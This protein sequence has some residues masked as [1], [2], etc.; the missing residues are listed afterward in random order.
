MS[1]EARRLS[2]IVLLRENAGERHLRLTL[3]DPEHGL[4][5]CLY[6]PAAKSGAATVTPDLFDTCEATLDTPRTGETSRFVKEYRLVLRRD[7][8]GRDYARLTLACRLASVLAK[9][10]H[11]PES[12]ARLAELADHA[13]ASLA[14]KPRPDAAYFKTLWL[15]ARDEGWAVKEDFLTRLRP[16]ERDLATLL[17]ATPL[18]AIDDASAPKALV[19]GLSQA[20]ER[21]LEREA[22]FVF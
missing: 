18:A 2:G 8:F 5:R 22:H 4:V 11:P 17:L 14:A 9:N 19:S 20:L 13:F 15:I 12:F 21:W 10:P 3:L 1:D 7:A 16:G 6:K